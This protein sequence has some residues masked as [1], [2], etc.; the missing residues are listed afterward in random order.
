MPG[1]SLLCPFARSTILY[2]SVVPCLRLREEGGGGGAGE[3][4]FVDYVITIYI[5]LPIFV[6]TTFVN[7]VIGQFVI[8]WSNLDYVIW[9]EG[10]VL[11]TV[12]YGGAVGE[13]GLGVKITKIL[14]T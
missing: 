9:G 1:L 7:Y 6:M 2:V 12:D 13:E 10:W 8:Q 5:F 14:I 11:I 3:G 4:L